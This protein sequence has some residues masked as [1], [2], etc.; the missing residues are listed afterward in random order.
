M[1]YYFAVNNYKKINIMKSKRI[2]LIAVAFFL[3]FLKVGAQKVC[4][5]WNGY[6][7]SKNK[8]GT[9]YI[10]LVVG[11]E[12]Q[13]SQTYHYAGPGRVNSV[14]I[15]G[16][17]SGILI[18][19]R[20]SIYN[21]DS[22]G[23]PTSEIKGENIT[24]WFYNSNYRE[25]SFS[26]GGVAVS[27]NFAVVVT[28]RTG[29]GGAPNGTTFQV[30][31]T[32]NGEGKNADLASLAGTST[33][34]NWA[35]AMSI[36]NKD[37]DFYLIPKM[38]HDI[39][40]GF[41]TSAKC[42][43]TSTNVSFTNTSKL[44]TDSMFN[45]ILWSG[46][47]GSSKIFAW[48][49]GDGGTSVLMNPT[50]VFSV[51]GSY[52]VRLIT[53]LVG[54]NTAKSDTAF[55]KISVGLGVSATSV[56][57]ANCYNSNNGSVTALGSGGTQNYQY[58]LNGL[59]YQSGTTF[60]NLP[61]GAHTLYIMDAL[62]CKANSTFNITQ[63][64]A[65]SFS[66]LSTNSASCSG[67]D[68]EIL[69]VATGG[70]GAIKY[71]LNNGSYQSGGS[72][73]GLAAGSYTIT[74]ADANNCMNSSFV[75]VNNTSAPKLTV[76][77]V[78]NV[79]CNGSN[80]GSITLASS[81]GTGAVQYSING[82]ASFQASGSF[83]NLTAGTYSAL[84]KDAAGCSQGEIVEITQPNRIDFYVASVPATCF[85]KQNGE[86]HL[87]SAIGGIGKLSYSVNGTNYQSSPDFTGLRAGN[88]TVYAKDI[89]SCIV[90]KSIAITQPTEIIASKIV[91]DA[92]CNGSNT[93][94][95]LVSVSG[96]TPSYTFSLND[97]NYQAT[98]LFNDLGAG[99]YN[100]IV[101]DNN[102]CKDTIAAT[103][104]QAALLTASVNTT[105][106]TCGNTNGSILVTAAGGTGSNY[107]YSLDGTTWVSSGL[108]SNKAA[109]TYYIVIKDAAG[110]LTVV[111]STIMDSNGPTFGTISNTSV[112]CNGGN[113]GTIT[114]NSVSG[115]SGTILYSLDG[116][117]WQT[118]NQ[119][120]NLTAG[121][122]N[123]IIKDGNGCRSNSNIVNL[124]QPNAI[125]ITKQVTN[126]TCYGTNNG[127]VNITAIGGSGTLA[128][129]IDNG[130]T[131]QSDKLFDQ[132]YAGVYSVIVRD[133]GG[134]TNS[135]SVTITQPTQISPETNIAIL[136]VS[137]HGAEDAEISISAIGGKPPYTYS[138]GNGFQTS[139]TFTGLSGGEYIVYIKDANNCV[140]GKQASVF[141]P[142][143][144]AV[145]SE[146]SNVSCA[147]GS[148]GGISLRV[149]GG[150]SPYTYLWSNQADKDYVFNLVAGTYTVFVTD[151]NGCS[152]FK[153]Y[154]ITQPSSPIVVNGVVTNTLSNSG[155]IDITV[156]GGIQPYRFEWSNGKTT[157][158][159]S[160]LTIGNYTVIVTDASRCVT[161]SQFTV[162]NSASIDKQDLMRAINLYPNPSS[163]KV[164]I[165]A[166]N[167]TIENLQ[168]QNSL[169][170][171]V[172]EF[173]PNGSSIVV[174]IAMLPPGIYM[175][176][177]VSEGYKTTQKLIISR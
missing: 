42:I 43:N 114:V 127:S 141:E 125:V 65:L 26:G 62:G 20:V 139:N 81:G 130:R 37:G 135:T 3:G 170:Q 153:T 157:E 169:G 137:C 48:D 83:S 100:I 44:S 94:S 128:Y 133:A 89:A 35:S 69:A 85:N 175:V 145:V 93:G 121:L 77:S 111:Y 158:D 95:I 75:I 97:F 122:Y 7:D 98:G 72:F 73:S 102:Q 112:T 171:T 24:W 92:I 58:S 67:N 68:G 57:N 2:T 108:F 54:W 55:S 140:V 56:N 124:V 9:G 8:S 30:K 22:K 151:A 13:A 74:A 14:R 147:G 21:V 113:D 87:T 86:I 162:Q 82:G 70:V 1:W 155:K 134:C 45:T 59:I 4:E 11:Y 19:L 29:V 51:A 46:Y 110:C 84:V 144:L 96:G 52:N 107:L 164:K 40:A 104:G 33:G 50:H 53:T 161:T 117:N 156:T 154:T 119:F 16:A 38:S 90:S 36:Y 71:K 80:D 126:V 136:N 5:D 149:T 109:G 39:T 142:D 47:Q 146:L 32:G 148:N 166:G 76:N 115:G 15:Y 6:V 159:V 34:G 150:V 165:E 64:T 91:T 172:L 105:N 116:V 12:E 28:V 25:V 27:A 101:K 118:S 173:N 120:K 174:D 131:F 123:V 160:G 10:N 168:I 17:F 132:L 31:Y 63:P 49:F 106:S 176:Q 60:N 167:Y 99:N 163:E 103:I 78:T 143:E 129:S 23:R 61:A 138:L 41:T 18:P 177:I 152:K 66:S 79:S 88:Y